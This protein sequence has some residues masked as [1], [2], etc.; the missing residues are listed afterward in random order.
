MVTTCIAVG[1]TEDEIVLPKY[2]I[3]RSGIILG[4]G[5][6]VIVREELTN[7]VGLFG[8]DLGLEDCSKVLSRDLVG[9]D[10][11]QENTHYF[12]GS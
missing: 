4:D 1:S 9:G 3:D 11:G 12:V 8:G 7:C 6:D 5:H 10:S 2:T